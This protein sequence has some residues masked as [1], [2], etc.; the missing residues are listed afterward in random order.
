MD[1]YGGYFIAYADMI[2]IVRIITER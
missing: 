1:Q 2:T